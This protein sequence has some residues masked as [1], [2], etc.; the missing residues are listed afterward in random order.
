MLAGTSERGQCPRCGAPWRRET[1]AHYEQPA[2]RQRPTST[3]SR[4]RYA[5]DT[6]GVGYRPEQVLSR[7]NTTTGWQPTCQ[8]NE[9]EAVPQV[10]L[11]PF[12]G[13]GTTLAVARFHQRQAIGIEL[14]ASYAALVERRLAQG[15]LL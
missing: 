11:D 4:E 10:V 8:C 1:T 14:N 9:P 3:E 5:G 15:V 12:C 7:V 13:S 6:G 2:T